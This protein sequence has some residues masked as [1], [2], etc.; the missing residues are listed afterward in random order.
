MLSGTPRPRSPILIS[1]DDEIPEGEP[2]TGTKSSG[3]VSRPTFKELSPQSSSKSNFVGIEDQ[4]RNWPRVDPI[5][6]NQFESQEG[7]LTEKETKDLYE[8]YYTNEQLPTVADDPRLDALTGGHTGRICHSNKM[9]RYIELVQ[10]MKDKQKSDMLVE[11]YRVCVTK[12]EQSKLNDNYLF[13]EK[14]IFDDLK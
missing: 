4:L 14:V 7:F 10:T 1:E 11:H 12:E 9:H 5:F 6:T 2:S 3:T 8:K 13:T